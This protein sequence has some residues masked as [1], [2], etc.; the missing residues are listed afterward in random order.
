VN[1][2]LSAGQLAPSYNLS[3]MTNPQMLR[4]LLVVVLVAV[5]LITAGRADAEAPK[6][7][8]EASGWL[9]WGP[10]PD[11]PWEARSKNQMGAGIA[12]VS[13]S[14]SG[15]VTDVQMQQSTGYPL[16]DR[17]ILNRLREWRFKPG[18]PS[19][20]GIP[21]H[22][23]SGGS[24]I[25]E[26]REKES[27]SM[28]ELLAAFLGKGAVLYGPIPRYP[29]Y[30]WVNKQGKGVYELHVGSDGKV[31]NVKILKG[32]GDATFDRVTVETLRKWRLRSGPKIIELPL[33]FK[34]TP[35]SYDVSIP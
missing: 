8:A 12:V 35:K 1:I 21:V 9:L 24:V 3:R 7:F 5:A 22:F 14:S 15:A 4:S 19:H 25:T 28:D 13:I 17:A 30:D 29:S 2:A 26:V 27:K 23:G 34:L 11:Y 10:K 20:I 32:S 16:L 6:A 18:A 31:A 33:A